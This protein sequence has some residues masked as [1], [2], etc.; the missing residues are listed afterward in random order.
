[1]V[2]LTRRAEEMK[3]VVEEYG[4][5]G[6]TRREFCQRR[7]MAV[8]TFDYWRRELAGKPKLV[9]VEVAA[10]EPSPHFTL[11]LSNGR[12]IESSWRYVEAELARLIRI[13]ESA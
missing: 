6:L 3:R 12:R 10:H 11:A 5:S 2:K 4:K 13:A 7:G 8:T 1:M 9:K